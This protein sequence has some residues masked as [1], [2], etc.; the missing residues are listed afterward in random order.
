MYA[1]WA[2]AE[3]DSLISQANKEYERA[4]GNW[5]PASGAFPSWLKRYREFVQAGLPLTESLE[6]AEKAQ[7]TIMGIKSEAFRSTAA[8]KAVLEYMKRASAIFEQRR[9]EP[10]ANFD[11]RAGSSD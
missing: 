1:P 5:W 3:Y 10:E 8:M 11:R 4:S 2:R 7:Y 6:D 9:A